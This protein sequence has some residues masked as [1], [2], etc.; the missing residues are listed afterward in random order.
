MAFLDELAP[1]G[2]RVCVYPEDEAGLIPLDRVVSEPRSEVRIY[3][4]GPGP[5]LDA[6]EAATAHWPPGSLHTERFAAKP[7]AAGAGALEAFEVVCQRS[8]VTLNIGSGQ[9]IL[10]AAEDAGLKVLSSCRAG[11]CGTCDVDVLGG[12]PDHRDSVLS[13]DERESNEFMLICISRSL[14][15]RL[16]LDM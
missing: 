15:P 12:T 11:V 16:V 8:G 3:S 2:D 6:V 5:L 7:V 14:S 4:C 10:D 1:Y 13:A 9:S